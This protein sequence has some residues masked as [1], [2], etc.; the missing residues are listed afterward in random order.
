MATERAFL[1]WKKPVAG[2]RDKIHLNVIFHGP[3]LFIVY[4]NRIE[5]LTGK[6]GE[7]LFGSGN[8][9]TERPCSPGTYTLMGVETVQE[10]MNAIDPQLHAV[11]DAKKLGVKISPESYYTFVVPKPS[12]FTA[13]GMMDPEGPVFAGKA[14]AT[15]KPKSLGTAHLLHY[16]ISD[17][18]APQLDNLLWVPNIV[19]TGNVR[20]ASLHVFAESPFFLDPF[21]PHRDF[22]KNLELLDGLELGLARPLPKI[23]FRAVDISKYGLLK[24]EQGGLRGLPPTTH[25][26]P[27]LICDSPSLVVVNVGEGL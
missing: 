2:N 25:L 23:N 10:K 5:V 16:L 14:A 13:V 24:E 27:P 9:Q 3:F 1:P 26:H 12:Y 21:H 8:W 11:I 7:H 15:I 6:I 20:H 18:D 17:N 22:A 4:P 19:T